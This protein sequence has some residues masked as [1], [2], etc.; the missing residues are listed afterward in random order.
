MLALQQRHAALFNMLA[1]AIAPTDQN[2]CGLTNILSSGIDFK[3]VTRTF[4]SV[5]GFF[6]IRPKMS[7]ARVVTI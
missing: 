7:V 5:D 6:K 1:I 2:S 3:N 4:Y